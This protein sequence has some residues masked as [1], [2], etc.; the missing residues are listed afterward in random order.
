MR[1]R[2]TYRSS[3]SPR[4]GI[5]RN[6]RQCPRCKKFGTYAPDCLVCDRCVG[7]LPLIFALAVVVFIGGV[8]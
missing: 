1:I 3:T 4:Y 8:R 2:T 6:G 7:A 5:P